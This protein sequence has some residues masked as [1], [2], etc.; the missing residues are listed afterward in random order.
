MASLPS[1]MRVVEHDFS[2]STLTMTTAALPTPDFAGD[3]HLIKVLAVAPCA[4]E[5][6]WPRPAELNLSVPG[7]DAVGTVIAG[8]PTSSF[9]PGHRVYY[10]TQY[11][12]AANLREYSVALTNELALAPSNFPAVEAVVIPVSAMTAYQALFSQFK[13]PLLDA[14]SSAPKGP[15]PRILINGGSSSVGIWALQL[16]RLANLATIATASPKNADF[17]KSFGADEIIDYTSTTPGAWA[18]SPADD[19]TSRKVDYV[20]DTV[21]R[22]SIDTL[23]PALKP[24]GRLLTIVP[25]ANMDFGWVPEPAVDA[26]GIEEG[27]FGKFFIMQTDGKQLSEITKLVEAGKCRGVVDSVFKLEDFQEAFRKVD[28]GRAVG[29]VVIEVAEA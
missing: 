8:P 10:R 13:L 5:L 6:S 27:V 9:Q 7:S 14:T 19:G 15:K 24:N 28:S 12:R 4:G 18:S 2:R 3:Q 29:K 23:W 25:P 20:L 17:V 26:E 22:E 11:P 21:G 16:A 1:N